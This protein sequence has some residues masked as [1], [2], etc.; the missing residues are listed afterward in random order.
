MASKKE[1]KKYIVLV[2][3][4]KILTH[5]IER[6]LEKRGYTVKSVGD[7]EKALALIRSVNPNL[8]LLDIMLPTMN[9]FMIL[10]AL[11]EEKI[12][13]GL[14]VIIISN[15]GEPIEVERALKLGVRGYLVKA[16]LTPNE[17]GEKVDSF[18][19]RIADSEGEQ[20]REKKPALPIE[21]RTSNGAKKKNL[22][23]VEDD[24]ILVGLLKRKAE[25]SDYGVFSAMHVD[26]ARAILE[27]NS[28]DGIL[29]DIVL[30]DTDGLT[31]LTELKSSV[32]TKD[33]P[34]VIVS[35]LGQKEEI[36]R[37]KKMGAADYLIKA[38]ILPT[39][40]IQRVDAIL[41]KAHTP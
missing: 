26:E 31:F 21:N 5:L 7:G 33:I 2:E 23:I 27:K 9:G 6:N 11:S 37:G 20:K 41:K 10:D 24:I 22:L 34:V 4:D 18:F 28:I 35:N 39:D 32:R 1:G 40:I 12:L 16:D 17:V 36:E 25:Q 19:G 30:P 14:P 29:L 15:S 13:P 3:D 38:N 8:V